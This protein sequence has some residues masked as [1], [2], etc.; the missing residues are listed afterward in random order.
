[1]VQILASRSI[2]NLAHLAYM[3]E[4]ITYRL[5]MMRYTPELGFDYICFL[6]TRLPICF[7][8]IELQISMLGVEMTYTFVYITVIM[9]NSCL[10]LAL[11]QL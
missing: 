5:G 11:F 10:M 6:D 9:E 1:M 7:E 8:L 3:F 4:S 2:A